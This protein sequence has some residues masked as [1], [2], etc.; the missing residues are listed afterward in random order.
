V[1]PE[2]DIQKQVGLISELSATRDALTRDLARLRDRLESSGPLIGG[3][4]L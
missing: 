3:S 1:V 2:A 4:G